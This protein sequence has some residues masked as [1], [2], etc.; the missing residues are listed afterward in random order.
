MLTVATATR[1]FLRHVINRYG[2]GQHPLA[3]PNGLLHFQ[4]DYVRECVERALPL[5][6][7]S[8]AG[9]E[10]ANEYLRSPSLGLPVTRR[11][12]MQA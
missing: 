12:H 2:T 9:R 4:P 6:N 1:D 3:E 8:D 11:P 7:L 5:G 10:L